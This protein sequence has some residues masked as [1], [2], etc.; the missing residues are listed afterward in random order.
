MKCSKCENTV[1]CVSIKD[2]DTG[3]WH[4]EWR[5]D[6]HGKVDPTDHTFSQMEIDKMFQDMLDVYDTIDS[7][8]NLSDTE[9]KPAETSD[10]FED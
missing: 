4:N 5:C 6:D 9:L 7:F 10:I 3:M 1:E 2:G 8:K